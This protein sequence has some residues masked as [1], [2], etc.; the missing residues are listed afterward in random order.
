MDENS[1]SIQKQ[2]V[3]LTSFFENIINK[4]SPA[5]WNE[6]K[7]LIL[8]SVKNIEA[9]IDP[10]RFEQVIVNLLENARKYSD[11]NTTTL[12]EVKEIQNKIHIHIKDQGKGIPGKD[13]PRVFERFYR[14][15]KSRTRATGGS[16]LG[17]AIVKEIIEA[18][19]GTINIKS[20]LDKGTTVEIFL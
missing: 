10:I 18:H 2:R 7:R 4:M 16:G 20:A 8:K 6:N 15:D 14:V 12:L 19:N 17:L 1:F 3:N 5:F 11:S 9:N 13:L